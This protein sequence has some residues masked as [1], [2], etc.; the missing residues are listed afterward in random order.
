MF[1]FSSKDNILYQNTEKNSWKSRLFI[2]RTLSKNIKDFI[3]A[4]YYNWHVPI[5]GLIA[6]VMQLVSYIY[7]YKYLV[8]SNEKSGSTIYG[9]HER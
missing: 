5:T 6:F 4:W 7:D 8:L 1:T 9:A 3:D 2:K